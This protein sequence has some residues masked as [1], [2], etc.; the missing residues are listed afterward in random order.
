MHGVLTHIQNGWNVMHVQYCNYMYLVSIGWYCP[1][2]QQHIHYTINTHSGFQPVG[3]Q[4]G[5]L[6]GGGGGGGG[7][8]GILLPPPPPKLLSFP[9]TTLS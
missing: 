5:R 9:P 7:P 8:G 3:G 4:G 2:V 1:V 6:V